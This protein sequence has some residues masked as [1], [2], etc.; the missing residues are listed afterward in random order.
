MNGMLDG[1]VDRYLQG[2]SERDFDMPL[3]ALLVSRRFYD[4]HKLH[5]AF[6]FGKDFIAKREDDG[7][8]CQYAIQSKAG[9]INL[10]SWRM[11]RAQIDEARYNNIAHPSY[12][13]SLRKKA[14]LVT[15]GRLVGGAA[16]DAQQ[17]KEYLDSRGETSF[18][19]WD[20][21]K[22]REWLIRDPGCGM[23]GGMV[24]EM[25]AVVAAA[26][27]RAIGHQQLERY[28]VRWTVMPLYKVAIEA[29]VIA[30]KLRSCE[31]ADLAAITALCALRAAHSQPADENFQLFSVM[32]RQ[33]HAS[34]AT[35]LLRAYQHAVIDP[36]SLLDKL[37]ST[38]PHFTY[39]VVCY[40][41]AETLGLLAMA[42]HVE[43]DVAEAA[44]AAVKAIAS[45]QP[46]TGR[47]LSD[48]WAISLIC[49]VLPI[50]RDSPARAAELLKAVAAWVADSY[51]DRPGLAPVDSTE[52]E[53]IEYLIG[54][55]LSHI[56]ITRRRTSYLAT[57]VLDLCIFFGLRDLYL[58]AVHDFH[59]VNLVPTVLIADE[60]VAKWG[61][62]ESGIH[63]I[64]LVRYDERWNTNIRVPPY[65]NI[66]APDYLPAWD[67][68]ALACLPR[69]RHPFWTFSQMCPVDAVPVDRGDPANQTRPDRADPA[70]S[71][72]SEKSHGR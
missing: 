47:P 45:K 70:T 18:E 67:A 52:L 51:D 40:R 27:Q 28:T 60:R 62:G 8:V 34:Y 43:E 42:E 4:I 46:G 32:A 56:I 10:A 72:E 26:E 68:L 29:A 24:A 14:I 31:R 57:T 23:A 15:T 65:G 25:L 17:Y 35:G 22:L 20:R 6:E 71:N 38:N 50:F 44:R 59:A 63:S 16:A 5:G 69:N 37:G 41:L 1:V 61:A 53:E 66:S 13:L 12:S 55:P 3:M 21:D 2:V 64:P 39:P 54:E 7:A 49:A 19:V 33:L 36:K 9:D 58:Q 30:D 48:R 11:V